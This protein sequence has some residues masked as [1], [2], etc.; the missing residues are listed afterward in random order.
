LPPES[1][2]VPCGLGCPGVTPVTMSNRKTRALSER[3]RSAESPNPADV[4]LLGELLIEFNGAMGEV[5]S[6]LADIGLPAVT[7]LKTTGT[8][9]DKL[10]RAPHLHLGNI[11]DLAGARIVQ[12]MTLDEQDNMAQAVL[13]L[14][15]DTPPPI[16]R[17]ANPSF[18]YRAV[19]VVPRVGGCQVEVQLRTLYQDTWAQV[20]ESFGDWW[21]RAIR[22]GGEPDD[23]D[24]LVGTGPLTR[25]AMVHWWLE[26]SDPLHVLARLENERAAL[27]QVGHDAATHK[28]LAEVEVSIDQ[29]FQPLRS[30]ILELAPSFSSAVSTRVDS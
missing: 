30:V 5:Q 6:R 1:S 17:R 21:G 12:R 3:L 10:K 18:G 23:P 11:R 28:R 20:M 8:I 7:R 19:H 14:W 27:R 15:P 4:A 22:Y 2:E 25:R 16:D 29:A 9:I 26:I 13:D 24:T